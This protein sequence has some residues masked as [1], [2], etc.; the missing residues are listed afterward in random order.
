MREKERESN[1]NPFNK[2]IIDEIYRTFTVR[3]GGAN[4]LLLSSRNPGNISG[5]APLR[6]DLRARTNEPR[7]ALDAKRW[8]TSVRQSSIGQQLAALTATTRH[9]QRYRP[10]F[11]PR[12]STFQSSGIPTIPLRV[13]NNVLPLAKYWQTSFHSLI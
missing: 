4:V 2:L 7:P 6:L 11:I 8:C 3:V 1:I 9:D 5:L 12:P 13:I 10:K